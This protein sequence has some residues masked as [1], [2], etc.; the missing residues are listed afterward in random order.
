MSS[1]NPVRAFESYLEKAGGALISAS[2]HEACALL[3]RAI[4]QFEI[5]LGNPGK[6]TAAAIA[7]LQIQ[8]K[9]LTMLAGE[10][11]RITSTW[12]EAIAPAAEMQHSGGVDIYG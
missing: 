1:H 6:I 2:P 9:N 7:G 11:E 3:S 4:A 12:L 5:V 8:I 10:G